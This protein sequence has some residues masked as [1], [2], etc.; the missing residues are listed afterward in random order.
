MGAAVSKTL[1]MMER[2]EMTKHVRRVS[3]DLWNCLEGLKEA[4]ACI[5]GH[6]GMGLMQG[7]EVTVPA[8]EISKKALERGLI[9]ITAGTNVLRFLPPL[10]IERWHVEEMAK[11]LDGVLAE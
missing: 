9:L 11:I 10:V 2:D 6:R 5:A 4:H 3:E 1:E 8:G 7:L